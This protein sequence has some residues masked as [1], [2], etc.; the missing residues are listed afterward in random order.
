MIIVSGP[1]WVDESVRDSFLDGCRA[2]VMAARAAEGC[3]DFH[4][5][6]DPLEGDRINVYEEWASI[7][8]AAAFRGSGP[9]PEQAS[10]IRDARLMQHDVSSSTRL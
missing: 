8:A 9:T 10:V 1:L 5:S 7:E 2:V 6:A 3:L 4:L